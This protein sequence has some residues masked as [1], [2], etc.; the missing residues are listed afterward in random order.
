[1]TLKP[2]HLGE[3][4]MHVAMN[5]QKVDVQMTTEHSEVKKLI[6]QSVHELR[7]GLASH[8]LNMEKLNVSLNDK[9][10]QNSFQQGQKD[11]GQAKEFAQ[12][13]HQQNQN[14]REMSQFDIPGMPNSNSNL[15][16]RAEGASR[17]MANQMGRSSGRLNVVA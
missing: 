12:A 2:E 3:I 9:S 4:H 7:H 15:S 10:A 13:F 1:M 6:E 16:S 17:M 14:R 5:G 8:N 11:F